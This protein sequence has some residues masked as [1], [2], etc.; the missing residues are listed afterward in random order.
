MS[1]YSPS[2]PNILNL[3]SSH[4]VMISTGENFIYFYG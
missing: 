2:F 3:C 4:M 1:K